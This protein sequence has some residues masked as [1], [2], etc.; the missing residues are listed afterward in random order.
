MS[1]LQPENAALA[2]ECA[3]LKRLTAELIERQ[4]KERSRLAGQLQHDLAQL[5][6]ALKMHVELAA[7]AMPQAPRNDHLAEARALVDRMIA[8][9]RG[10][11]LELRPPMLD[12]LGLLPT[13]LWYVDLA[14]RETGVTYDLR[15][16]GLDR[17][18]PPVLETASFRVV[19]EL[20]SNVARH[21]ATDRATL[22][23]WADDRRL[24]LQVE[25][26]GCGFCPEAVLAGD[27]GRGL[28]RVQE[29]VN[30]LGGTLTVDSR[31]GGGARITVE[32]PL[33]PEAEDEA[34]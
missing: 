9:V 21:A 32:F 23:L 30:W 3:R 1:P 34:S 28:M 31:P 17:R 16:R 33:N 2:A 8:W 10:I 15:H 18:F 20:L 6:S 5:L 26:G 19:Q 24:G 4:E 7:G 25:D 27:T 11:S 22:R 29:R 12:D 14:Q 13:V